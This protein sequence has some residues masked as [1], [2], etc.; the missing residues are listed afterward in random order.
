M[1]LGSGDFLLTLPVNS[2][3][4][5]SLTFTDLVAPYTPGAPNIAVPQTPT[6]QLSQLSSN[7]V[8]LVWDDIFTFGVDL[9]GFEVFKTVNGTDF[10]YTSP[11]DTPTMNM[12]VDPEVSPGDVYDYR[13]RSNHQFGVTSNLSN[14]LTVT[15]PYP[16]PPSAIQ[17]V[18]ALDVPDDEGG[19]L[20]VS[21]DIGPEI[22]NSYEIYVTDY[23]HNTTSNLTPVVSLSDRTQL[24]TVVD[25]TSIVSDILGIQSG[26]LELVDGTAYFVSVVGVDEF[27][28]KS[29]EVT[30]VGPVYSRNDSIRSPDVLLDV[31]GIIEYEQGQF[32]LQPYGEFE[33]A[34]IVSIDSV[35]ASGLDAYINLS[36]INYSNTF[37]GVTDDNGTFVAFDADNLS[38]YLN[39]DIILGEI[40]IDYG[41]LSTLEDPLVQPVSAFHSSQNIESVVT[42]ST[43]YPQ[44]SEIDDA[45]IFEINLS[46]DSSFAPGFDLSGIVYNYSI[47]DDSAGVVSTGQTE[48][49]SDGKFTV[50]GQELSAAQMYFEIST[51]PEFVFIST[52]NFVVNLTSQIVEQNNTETNQTENQTDGG[53]NTVDPIDNNPTTISDVTLEGCDSINQVA[54][55][56]QMDQLVCTIINPNSFAVDVQI[57]FVSS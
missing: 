4:A 56:E 50:I 12:S 19:A 5:G 33:V 21:W 29:T 26:G 51:M 43:N 11:F 17:N 27:G 16:L 24:S 54:G 37:T 8:M 14:I 47:L 6:L 9:M 3:K 30:S 10:D 25:K 32:A 40:T 48:S 31:D 36:H 23:E 35:P 53:N 45:G 57:S 44:E 52:S 55:V 7:T 1:T 18:S 34:I 28:N 42:T 46:V 39:S 2:T 38:E 13:V 20:Q 49:D 15:I 41:I 22:V